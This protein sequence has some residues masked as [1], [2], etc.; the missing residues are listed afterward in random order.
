MPRK[1]FLIT[2]AASTAMLAVQATAQDYTPAE[3]YYDLSDMPQTGMYPQGGSKPGAGNASGPPPKGDVQPQEVRV[4]PATFSVNYPIF[5]DFASLPD[6]V[7]YVRQP[8]QSFERREGGTH[9][10]EVV[11]VESTNVS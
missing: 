3:N 2:L 11:L 10:Y 4:G 5:D 1:F 6:D 7:V 9:Y 8:I